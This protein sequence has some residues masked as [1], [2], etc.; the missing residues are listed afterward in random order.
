MI[1]KEIQLRKYGIRISNSAGLTLIA[2]PCV[3]E[4]KE[5]TI[6][7]ASELGSIAAGL[8]I[9]FI[10]KASY[11]KANRSSAGSFRGPGLKKGVEILKAV[12]KELGIPVLTDVHAVSE[13][14]TAA[15]VADILQVPAFLCRQTDLVVACAKTGLPVNVKKG[16][17]VA[18]EDMVNIIKKAESAS[19]R[20]IMLT[21]RGASFGY[22]NLVVDMRSIPQMKNT[23]YPVIFDATHSVQLPGQ[24]GGSSGGQREYILPLSRASVSLGIAGL[25]LEVHPDPSKAR[26]DGPNSLSLRELPG[27]LRKIMA[28]DRFVKSNY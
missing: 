23:G 10:F 24:R 18:P 27:F 8:G 12:K 15:R 4:T 16:Q 13:V 25:F 26:S 14:P 28:L 21:E 2:G 11:D 22:H 3:I 6:K 1:E 5:L 17:F 19:N 7:I 20:N 9:P